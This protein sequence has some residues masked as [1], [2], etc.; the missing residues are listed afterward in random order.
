MKNITKTT[1]AS[2]KGTLIYCPHCNTAGLVYKFDWKAAMCHNCN[3]WF[4]KTEFL[5]DPDIPMLAKEFRI[6]L[7]GIM[8]SGTIKKFLQRTPKESIIRDAKKTAFAMPD[9]LL[10]KIFTNADQ[11]FNNLKNDNNLEIDPKTIE[12]IA[13]IVRY[14]Y[15]KEEAKDISELRKQKMLK[16]K[17]NSTS[18]I[19]VKKVSKSQ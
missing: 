9:H 7:S 3:K 5:I 11:I 8:T 19:T 13:C 12:R 18:G 2:K 14:F 10:V 6:F 15:E 17:K 4:N 1:R 16:I